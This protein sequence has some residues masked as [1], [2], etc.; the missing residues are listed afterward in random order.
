VKRMYPV[1][2]CVWMLSSN[3]KMYEKSNEK[4]EQIEDAKIYVRVKF[5]M[6]HKIVQGDI[7]K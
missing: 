5:E 1:L 2:P 6:Q 7:N 4:H 3:Q